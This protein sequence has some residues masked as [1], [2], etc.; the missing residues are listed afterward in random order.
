MKNACPPDP[1]IGGE[2][3]ENDGKMGNGIRQKAKG[4]RRKREGEK[5]GSGRRHKA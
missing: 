4:N 1:P 3:G 5:M 2:G